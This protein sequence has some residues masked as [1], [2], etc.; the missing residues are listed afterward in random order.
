[1]PT[2]RPNPKINSFTHSANEHPNPG[3]MR[4]TEWLNLNGVWDFYYDT[5]HSSIEVPFAWE[6][7]ASTVSLT[8]LQEAT[9][10]R[11]V[12]IPKHWIGSRVFI[13]FGAV[14]HEARIYID[15]EKISSHIGGYTPFEVE[16]TD[17][18]IPGE[19]FILRV[20]V[21]SPID[22]RTIPHGKSRS[23]P[24]DD[25]DGVSFTP[26][27]G[28]WQT[29]WIEKRGK[30]FIANAQVS[31]DSLDQFD[32]NLTFSDTLPSGSTLHVRF[33]EESQEP[34]FSL[35]VS[36]LSKAHFSLPVRSPH[37]W[38]LSDPH[39]Y[40]IVLRLQTGETLQDEL[41]LKTGLRHFEIHDSAFFL[42]GKRIYLKGVLDQGYWP[43]YGLT[44]PN[45]EALAKD[46]TLARKMGFNLIRKHLKFEDPRWLYEADR[47]GILVWSEPPST[48]RYSHNSTEIYTQQMR[49]VFLRDS[50]HPCIVIWSLYNEEWGL[51]WGLRG[52]KERQESV[53]RLVENMRKIDSTRPIVDNSGWS[54]VSTDI[55]DWHYYEKDLEIW[56]E[57]LE[58]IA[59]GHRGDFPVKLDVDFIVDK[60]LWA[61][62]EFS[63]TDLPLMNS[64][65]GEGF[66][67]LERGWYFR[68]Q[69]QE[70]RR[71]DRFSG[72]VY[73]EFTDVEHE[74]AGLLTAQ[75]VAKDLGG[76]DPATVNAET[77]VILDLIPSAPGADIAVPVSSFSLGVAI[78]HHGTSPVTLRVAAEWS[79]YG[80]LHTA[81]PS[82]R[83]SYSDPITATPF[84][85][86]QF[87]FV[88]VPEISQPA[89]LFLWA[90]D[91]EGLVRAR[92]FLDAAEIEVPNR[93]GA[94]LGEF[95][96]V[97]QPG[98]P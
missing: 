44:A 16:I 85:T 18:I 65:Y 48:S 62:P 12:T 94:R 66:T 22:K 38:S 78:S 2:K 14:F 68:W 6:T 53:R 96:G 8:W 93:R 63:C 24:R 50:N 77:V 17:H 27:S 72:Y 35:D 36:A 40:E 37:L 74:N 42:N 54:H 3:C 26:N 43:S 1:M 71:N 76:L 88:T 89:R 61:E 81:H 52:S 73:T 9:Y 15:D 49:E 98:L 10:T 19:C 47:Q 75:R 13:R 95:E 60:H 32:F 25:Y 31:G 28:I 30:N 11:K 5:H 58:S 91:E 90:L 21:V 83:A 39:L 46:I 79:R 29:V 97:E 55:V 87:A 64:E 70:L 67:S 20:D 57:R 92:A 82:D 23:I 7:E 59:S 80:A 84:Q 33:G 69:T 45:R 34:E 41:S 51:D 56:H 4:I 86:S